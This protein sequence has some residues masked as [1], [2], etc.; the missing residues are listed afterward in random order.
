MSGPVTSERRPTV[1]I[2]N[3]YTSGNVGDLAHLLGEVSLIEECGWDWRIVGHGDEDLSDSRFVLAPLTLSGGAGGSK[4]SQAERL[5]R[6]VVRLPRSTAPFR[7]AQAVLATGGGYVYTHHGKEM[8]FRLVNHVSQ[9]E[10]ARLSRHHF[11]ILP[12]TFGPFHSESASRVLAAAVRR[13]DWALCREEWSLAWARRN[14]IRAEWCPDLAFM[15]SWEHGQRSPVARGDRILVG[16]MSWGHPRAG[17]AERDAKRTAYIEQMRRL[18]RRLRAAGLRTV[19][20]FQVN[21]EFAADRDDAIA[22]LLVEEFDEIAV[23]ESPEQ[24]SDLMA[25]CRLAI[26]TRLHGGILA[27]GRGTPVIA[28]GYLPK[29][30]HIMR[31]AGLEGSAVGLDDF[32]RDGIDDLVD[33]YLGALDERQ[34]RAQEAGEGMAR[35]GRNVAGRYIAEHLARAA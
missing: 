2:T 29:H 31:S 6:Q 25:S 11:G 17:S 23:G 35:V 18:G 7:E 8:V 13:A 10:I 28:I 24:V 26:V 27:I 20:F 21:T 16:A 12:A 30:E 4:L 9:Y 32:I 19:L 33:D 34:A 22:P 5:G 1:L 14:R 15:W 3:F